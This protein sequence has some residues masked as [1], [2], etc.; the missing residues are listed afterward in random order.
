MVKKYS[1]SIS[2]YNNKPC[3]ASSQNQNLYSK[4]EE[5]QATAYINIA[6]VP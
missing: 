5:Q 6:F 1:I 3:I 4:F 2:Y